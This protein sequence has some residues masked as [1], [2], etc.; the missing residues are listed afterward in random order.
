MFWLIKDHVPAMSALD[1]ASRMVFYCFDN[2][3]SFLKE[4]S[5][6]E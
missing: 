4:V 6:A 2:L 1:L 3:A 5:D